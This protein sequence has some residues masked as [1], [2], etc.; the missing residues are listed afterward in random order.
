MMLSENVWVCSLLG[1]LGHLGLV[2]TALG[3]AWEGKRGR[4]LAEVGCPQWTSVHCGDPGAKRRCHH[5]FLGPH[6]PLLSPCDE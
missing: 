5:T 4:G 2:E 6:F 1:P 3:S